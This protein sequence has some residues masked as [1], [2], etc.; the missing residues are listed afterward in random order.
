MHEE[1]SGVVGEYISQAATVRRLAR[2]TR[3]PDIR[4][5]LLLMTVSFERL[6]EQVEKWESAG[7]TRAAD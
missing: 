5:R 2:E 6:A 3:Y 7:F 1:L 4:E